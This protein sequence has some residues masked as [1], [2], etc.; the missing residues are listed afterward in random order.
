MIEKACNDTRLEVSSQYRQQLLEKDRNYAEQLRA[1]DI[2]IQG[3]EEDLRRMVQRYT[4]LEQDLS[5]VQRHAAEVAEQS[6]S[7]NDQTAYVNK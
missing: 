4:Q 2:Q 3:K 6:R 1:K 7:A 5:E